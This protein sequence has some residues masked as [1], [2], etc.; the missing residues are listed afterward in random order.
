MLAEVQA[1]KNALRSVGVVNDSSAPVLAQ[2]VTA[3]PTELFGTNMDVWYKVI[4][5]YTPKTVFCNITWDEIKTLA[6]EEADCTALE[7]LQDRM[8]QHFHSLFGEDTKVEAFVKMSC[9]S[10]KDATAADER[11]KQEYAK[12][13]ASCPD[14]ST[15][16][17]NETFRLLAQAQM[18]ALCVSTPAAALEL[19]CQSRRV[20]ADMRL[21]VQHFFKEDKPETEVPVNIAIRRW[22]QIHLWSEVRGFVYQGRLTALSQYV[23]RISFP[24]MV[25]GKDELQAK[26]EDLF[27]N[28]KGDLAT[29][30]DTMESYII[31]F[32]LTHAG[33]VIVLELNPWSETTD[34][35][36]FSWVKDQKLL[37]GHNEGVEFRIIEVPDP[38]IRSCINDDWKPFF[39]TKTP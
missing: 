17:D 10:P 34:A 20:K 21:A 18:N 29:L 14:K 9:R 23:D 38:S 15:L 19:F 32:A 3:T 12:L 27:N 33:Q 16:S 36:L 30:K 11:M 25:A 22:E 7:S 1:K 35:C 6:S 26:I 2:S 13:L 31:D 4:E 28:V 8:Q 39:D 24:E 5:R 37:W